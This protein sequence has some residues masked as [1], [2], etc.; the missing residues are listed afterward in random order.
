M[1]VRTSL[2]VPLV[3]IVIFVVP[4][5]VYGVLSAATGLQPPGG[6]P[7]FLAGT[8]ISKLGTAMAFVL[9]FCLGRTVIG[10]SGWSMWVSGG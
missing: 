8:A 10:P 7:M 3:W 2:A 1:G 5:I 9:L 4:I 6:N